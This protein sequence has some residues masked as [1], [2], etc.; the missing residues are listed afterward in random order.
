VEE[1]SSHGCAPKIEDKKKIDGVKAVD[2]IDITYTQA[3][4]I[5]AEPVK[6]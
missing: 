5:A 1:H 3:L 6:Q 2:R 4:V